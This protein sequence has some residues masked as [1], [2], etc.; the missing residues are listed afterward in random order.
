M[1]GNPTFNPTQWQSVWC[2]SDV[3]PTEIGTIMLFQV[4]QMQVGNTRGFNI[5]LQRESVLQK[6]GSDE[7]DWKERR[8]SSN[9]SIIWGRGWQRELVA[10]IKM[11]HC[12][13]CSLPDP[14]PLIILTI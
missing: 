9:T 2:G 14:A 11:A 8:P 10:L 1:K 5:A 13:I 3:E 6:A 4:A 12:D 7:K